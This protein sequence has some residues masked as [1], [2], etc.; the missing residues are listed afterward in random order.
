MKRFTVLFDN[1][2]CEPEPWMHR[3]VQ[4]AKLFFVSNEAVTGEVVKLEEVQQYLLE[5]QGAREDSKLTPYFTAILERV[6]SGKARIALHGASW[7]L[8]GQRPDA[9]VVDL[10]ALEETKK[11]APSG[12]AELL[13]SYQQLL[14]E[15]VYS[16]VPLDRV[17]I[18]PAGA[19][20]DRKLELTLS[21]IERWDRPAK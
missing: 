8:Y 11:K 14:Q 2:P 3:C 17:L 1:S 6:A 16:Y 13:G 12:Q 4:T 21:F 19:P 20:P 10:D 18:L 15:R 9:C 5:S 7:L